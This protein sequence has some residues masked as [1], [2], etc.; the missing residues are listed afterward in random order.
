MSLET[1]LNVNVY[2]ASSS[3]MEQKRNTER[4]RKFIP[5][6]SLVPVPESLHLHR[7]GSLVG[8]LELELQ[9]P[10][11]PQE[12]GKPGLSRLSQ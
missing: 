11:D 7:Y 9:D 10:Q 3:C 8:R 2:L 6:D 5:A 1:L 12:P 4:H